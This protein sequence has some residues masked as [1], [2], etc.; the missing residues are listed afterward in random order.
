MSSTVGL[1]VDWFAQTLKGGRPI[2]AND[3][4]WHW[5]QRGTLL[6]LIGMF[7][8]LFPLG[9]ILLETRFFRS[10]R[11][12]EPVAKPVRGGGS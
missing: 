9:A 12:E 11:E 6:A 4:T 2:P 1:A 8:L 10:L 7:L 3:Q 5:K